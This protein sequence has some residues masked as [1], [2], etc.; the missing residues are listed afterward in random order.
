MAI[1]LDM[2]HFPVEVTEHPQRIIS[3]VPSLS[4][5][6]HDLG[7]GERLVGVTKFCVHPESLRSD[8][9]IIGGTKMLRHDV[10]TELMPDLILANKE[11]NNKSDIEALQEIFPVWIS[12]IN[13]LDEALEAIRAIGSLTNA[14]DAATS[15]AESIN[16][17][18]ISFTPPNPKPRVAYVI[19]NDPLMLAGSGTFIHDMLEQGGWTNAAEDYARYPAF[20][21]EGIKALQPDLI[22]LSSE[23]FPFKAKHKKLF[24]SIVPEE[25]IILVDGEP[26]S[27]YGSRLKDSF[28]YFSDLHLLNS[29]SHT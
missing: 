5:L 18:R 23:P 2:M 24:A 12:D 8:K 4:L 19:W 10:I 9:T 15:L 14:S 29:K 13:T 16:S 3:L 1:H 28:A 26:F 27:W 6:L 20:S 7:V 11:E 22:F 25:R 21:I 17:S